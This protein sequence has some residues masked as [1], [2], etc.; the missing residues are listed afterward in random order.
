MI[1]RPLF[2][3]TGSKWLMSENIVQ[4][5]PPHLIYVEPFIGGGSIY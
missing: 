3:R 5:F 1:T 4:Y 2:C